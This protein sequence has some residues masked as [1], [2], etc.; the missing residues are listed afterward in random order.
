MS[1]KPS[2]NLNKTICRQAARAADRTEA[3]EFKQKISGVRLTRV[4]FPV[5]ALFHAGIHCFTRASKVV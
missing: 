3:I 4:T 5:V 1:S 2:R